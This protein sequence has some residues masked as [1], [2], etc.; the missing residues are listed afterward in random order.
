VFVPPAFVAEVL[1]KVGDVVRG[2]SRVLLLLRSPSN[3]G[4]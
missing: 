4:G 3:A 1:V 2:G